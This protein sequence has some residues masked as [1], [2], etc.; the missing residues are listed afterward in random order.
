MQEPRV[1]NPF[2]NFPDQLTNHKIS[3]FSSCLDFW[4][5]VMDLTAL[6]DNVSVYIGSSPREREKEERNVRP[7]KK[8]PNTPPAPTAITVGPCP[9]F[10]KISRT[11]QHWKFTQHHRTTRTPHLCLEK[12]LF[13]FRYVSLP[14]ATLAR[15]FALRT[16][17]TDTK[18]PTDTDTNRKL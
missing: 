18:D 1:L 4:L 11:P 14:V 12:Y 8:C 7:E 17:S 13:F 2:P 6:L 3:C 15:A 10:I 16:L 9:T 5:V